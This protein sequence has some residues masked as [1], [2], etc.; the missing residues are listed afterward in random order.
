MKKLEME[1]KY[2]LD[3]ASRSIQ[4]RDQLCFVIIIIFYFQAVADQYFCI[5][6]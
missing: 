1:R 5:M 4:G 3:N 2:S 6:Q